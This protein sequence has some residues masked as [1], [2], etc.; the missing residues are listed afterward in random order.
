M[1][2]RPTD[3]EFPGPGHR[4]GGA[5]H[6]DLPLRRS[7]RQQQQRL[8][9]GSLRPRRLSRPFHL[10]LARDIDPPPMTT[11]ESPTTWSSVSLSWTVVADTSPG[12]SLDRDLRAESDSANGPSHA[13]VSP[14]TSAAAPLPAS[15]IPPSPLVE[16]GSPTPRT[17]CPTAITTC[18]FST[19][20]L[21]ISG[22]STTR[23]TR[24]PAGRSSVG[25]L[26]LVG[27]ATTRGL[28]LGGGGPLSYP[29]ASPQGRAGQFRH[30][31]S[32]VSASRVFQDPLGVH[33]AGPPPHF[34]G[35]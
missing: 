8:L 28:D 33:L 32:R 18:C 25:R 30:H 6:V 24:A 17:T 10:D 4:G 23:M 1:G 12:P 3:D 22:R 27:R 29:A 7:H 13:R 14:C 15:P 26:P 34:G 16:G 21:A 31:P 20:T 11:G 35:R 5:D 2:R 9:A 19:P